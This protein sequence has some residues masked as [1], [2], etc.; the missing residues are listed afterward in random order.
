M[1]FRP[2]FCA[3]ELHARVTVTSRPRIRLESCIFDAGCGRGRL[4]DS[5]VA[6]GVSQRS[7]LPYW[8]DDGSQRRQLAGKVAGQAAASRAGKRS[9]ESRKR[10]K[11]A[12]VGAEHT[13]AYVEQR[14]VEVAGR[15]GKLSRRRRRMD[16]AVAAADVHG[17]FSAS[18]NFLRLDADTQPQKLHALATNSPSRWSTLQS[19]RWRR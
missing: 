5:R 10:R 13:R 12:G 8:Y 2:T 15:L 17:P 16:D 1:K 19:S 14:D 6:P 18:Q 3:P 4:R 7:E 11:S 9:K